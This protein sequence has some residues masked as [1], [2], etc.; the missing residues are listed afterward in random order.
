M[1]TETTFPSPAAQAASLDKA[2]RK[3]EHLTEQLAAERVESG[4]A[5]TAA[6]E[7]GDTQK[8]HAK[9]KEAYAALERANAELDQALKVSNQQ[10][11]SLTARAEKAEVKL[12]AYEDLS[13]A[14]QKIDAL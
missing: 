11:K 3:I 2:N 12:Q 5:R 6:R 8:E 1:A 13:A 10:V 7:H 4:R 9:V 14:K